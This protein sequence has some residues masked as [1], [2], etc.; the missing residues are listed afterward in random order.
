MESFVRDMV[1][2]PGSPS[3]GPMEALLCLE[4]ERAFCYFCRPGRSGGK[5]GKKGRKAMSPTAGVYG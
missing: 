3:G 2:E 5:K 1:G 4:N